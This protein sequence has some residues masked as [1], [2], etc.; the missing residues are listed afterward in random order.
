M[1]VGDPAVG[2]DAVRPVGFVG[3]A[4]PVAHALHVEGFV[5]VFEEPEA[6]DAVVCAFVF[7]ERGAAEW[8][9]AVEGRV[10]ARGVEDLVDAGEGGR[11]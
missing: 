5:D 7:E 6:H 4:G 1:H 10:Y 11:D 2:E 3:G 9:G 8:G